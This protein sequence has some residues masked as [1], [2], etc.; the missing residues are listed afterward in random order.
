MKKKMISLILCI[1]VIELFLTGCKGE[2]SRS[3]T[4]SEASLISN[5]SDSSSKFG[6]AG[7]GIDLVGNPSSEDPDS[8]SLVGKWNITIE[9]TGKL[10]YA[11]SPCRTVIFDRNG[12]ASFFVH[13]RGYYLR[14]KVFGNTLYLYG[15]DNYSLT[16]SYTTSGDDMT[17]TLTAYSD[18][19]GRYSDVADAMKDIGFSSDSNLEVDDKW[20]VIRKDNYSTSDKFTGSTEYEYDGYGKIVQTTNYDENGESYN[21][22][23]KTRFYDSMGNLIFLSYDDESADGTYSTYEHEY[24]LLGS[25]TKTI[26]R[27]Y[28][29]F[30]VTD[31][32]EYEYSGDNITKETETKYDPDNYTTSTYIYDYTYDDKGNKIHEAVTEDDGT[33][34]EFDMTYDDHGNVLTTPYFGMKDDDKNAVISYYTYQYDSSGNMISKE[35]KETINDQEYI[36]DYT[37]TYDSNGNMSRSDMKSNLYDG[38]SDYYTLYTYMKLSEY[39][40]SKK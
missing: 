28:E 18:D 32:T 35:E 25:M 6:E 2:V 15:S 23:N 11:A 21:T 36:S 33:V 8:S 1:I 9:G 29:S 5:E 37:Y 13:L 3:M 20:V 16:G 39:L 19:G 40:A 38:A 4:A 24:S 17:M 30:I 14:Y 34:R 12:L 26:R 27:D 22:K 10:E 7:F 31:T